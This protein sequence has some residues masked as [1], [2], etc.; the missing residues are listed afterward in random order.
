MQSSRKV[1]PE[2]DVSLASHLLTFTD[3]VLLRLAASLKNV[4]GFFWGIVVAAAVIVGCE[5]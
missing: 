5:A 1:K 3:I 2:T 4:T